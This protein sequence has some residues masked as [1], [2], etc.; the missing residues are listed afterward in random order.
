[1]ILFYLIPHYTFYIGERDHLLHHNLFMIIYTIFTVYTILLT[2]SVKGANN[3]KTFIFTLFTPTLKNKRCKYPQCACLYSKY[4]GGVGGPQTIELLQ[5]LAR[6]VI[7]KP[8]I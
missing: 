1:M 5:I 2:F 7:K 4:G 8:E 3:L 6:L